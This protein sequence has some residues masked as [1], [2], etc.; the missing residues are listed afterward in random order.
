MYRWPVLLA[1]WAVAFM[2]FNAAYWKLASDDFHAGWALSDNL[3]HQLAMQ[4]YCTL[5]RDPPWLPAWIMANEYRYKAAALGN[6]MSQSMPILACLFIGHPLLRAFFG[7]FF[8]L[9]VLAIG[10]IMFMGLWDW[11]PFLPLYAV[12]ID[13]DRLILW[14]RSRLTGRGSGADRPAELGPTGAETQPIW[15][16][17]GIT[18]FVMCF[19]AYYVLVA[20][21]CRDCENHTYPFSSFPMYSDIKA[22][23]PLDQHRSYEAVGMRFEVAADRKIPDDALSLQ[24]VVYSFLPGLEEP[25][26]VEKGL[27]AMKA[28]LGDGIKQIALKKVIYQIPAYSS[29]PKPVP[30]YEGLVASLG[31]R[32]R[33]V[34]VTAVSAMDESGQHYLK[35]RSTGYRNPHFRFGYIVDYSDPCPKPLRVRQKGDRYYY[36]RQELIQAWMAT[37]EAVQNKRPHLFVVYVSDESLGQREHIY[38][39]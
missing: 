30:I 11:S 12:F 2:F 36:D 32:Q 7:S 33:F 16:Q 34:C 5:G 1:Q 25:E 27:L 26:L 31:E 22:K 6:L 19:L 13:W 20:F 23:R 9:E 10:A 37:G 21:S 14:L 28:S 17:V 15:R 39:R 29:D 38:L 35:V 4:H 18:L 24:R 8:F 3:R